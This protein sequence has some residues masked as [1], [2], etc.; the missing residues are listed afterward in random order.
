VQSTG[1]GQYQ[2]LLLATEP[3]P[4]K[5]KVFRF[6]ANAGQPSFA[7]L[8]AAVAVF[9]PHGGDLRALDVKLALKTMGARDLDRVV[10]ISVFSVVFLAV[11][12]ALLPKLVH[13]LDFGK[14]KIDCGKLG[15]GAALESH[16]VVITDARALEGWVLSVTTVSKKNGVETG[17]ST[18]DY[19]PIVPD[20]WERGEPVR[21]VLET[22]HGT[23]IQGKSLRGIART[24]M[25]E[26][27]GSQQREWFQKKLGVKLAKDVVLVE[28]QAES[29]TDLYT[30][31][32]VMA[33][34]GVVGG[35]L[36]WAIAHQRKK[37]KG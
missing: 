20:D 15:E 12:I 24:V 27:L 1:A 13:G 16:N 3:A 10:G 6:Y 32:G 25:W 29:S 22:K 5:H 36:A 34:M 19:T 37:K 8:V 14:Q 4:G 23:D 7:A 33:G 26:G 30:F 31:L 9:V 18:K 35:L 17:R 28:F 21:V 11:V 2:T